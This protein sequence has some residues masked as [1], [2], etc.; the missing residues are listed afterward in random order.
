MVVICQFYEMLQWDCLKSALISGTTEILL[1]L[2][3]KTVIKTVAAKAVIKSV[4][5]AAIKTVEAAGEVKRIP[6]SERVEMVERVERVEQ[7]SVTT[8][9]V[10][11]E[12]IRVP[13]AAYEYVN[14]NYED[15]QA[16]LE[17]YGFSNIVLLPVKDLRAKRAANVGNI[18]KVVING[19]DD[20]DAR[21]SFLP[22]ARIVIS[23]HVIKE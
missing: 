10:S 19:R 20:F 4:G 6:K 22:G 18:I 5:N 15:A 16:E 11:M 9:S 21:A 8:D 23:Y 1:G 13:R 12:S 3:A 17:A 2:A 14:V 7:A